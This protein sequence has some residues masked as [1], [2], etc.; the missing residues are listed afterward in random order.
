MED[1]IL[2]GCDKRERGIGGLKAGR[3]IGDARLGLRLAI[4]EDSGFFFFCFFA[5]SKGRWILV[6][7]VVCPPPPPHGK[8]N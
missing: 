7:V 1:A 5:G 4:C 3:Y 8:G 2:Y 6:V